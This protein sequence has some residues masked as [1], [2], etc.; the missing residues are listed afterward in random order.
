MRG[1]GRFSWRGRSPENIVK[2]LVF[3]HRT[4]S[5]L[6]FNFVDEDFLGPPALASDRVNRIAAA[7]NEAGLN[8]TFGIQ[9]RPNS[10]SDEIIDSLASV[11]LKYVFMGIESDDPE[12]FKRWGRQYC[13]DTWHFVRYLQKKEIE[14]NAGTLLFHPDC[15]FDGIRAFADK[16]RQ[17]G[18]LNCRTAI[19]RLD[20]M[21]GSFYYNQYV[22]EHPDEYWQ[23]II[24]LP[25]KHPEIN[26]FYQTFVRLRR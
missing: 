2:E 16:L 9:V 12:D 21:P 25:F 19:N 8:I 4:C 26:P 10:L 3:L 15:T 13:A 6:T 1:H 20:A 11:G 24:R 22:T 7:I 18:L 17:H 23:G 5:A 14:I